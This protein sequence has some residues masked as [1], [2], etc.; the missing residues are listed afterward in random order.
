MHLGQHVGQRRLHE[1]SP[2]HAVAEHDRPGGGQRSGRSTKVTDVLVA[3]CVVLAL[4][5]RLNQGLCREVG[6]ALEDQPVGV[7]RV[8]LGD[9]EDGFPRGVEDHDRAQAVVDLERHDQLAQPGGV[10]GSH[11]LVD[12]LGVGNQPDR[13]HLSPLQ[14]D[15]GIEGSVLSV[16][17]LVANPGLERPGD[18]A[19][20][21]VGTDDTENQHQ[22][23]E[24]QNDLGSDPHRRE[25]QSLSQHSSSFASR[26]HR[27]GS[28]RQAC[29]NRCAVA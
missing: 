5:D 8:R 18:E 21:Q 28:R 17:Q 6:A 27:P 25:R 2:D 10:S 24:R 14:L 12:A 23:E 13:R 3:E 19:G 9:L 22:E 16:D 29:P 11:R 15:G 26:L 20:R 1:H 4:Q 7:G